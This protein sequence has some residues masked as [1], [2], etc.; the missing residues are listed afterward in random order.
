MR[1]NRKSARKLYNFERKE[2]N[3]DMIKE[4]LCI[5][6]EHYIMELRM[7]FDDAVKSYNED[8]R[9][10]AM[11]KTEFDDLYE[12]VTDLACY[13]DESA[14]ERICSECFSLQYML[15]ALAKSKTGK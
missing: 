3:A 2:I 12:V 10:F 6:V 4:H 13:L 8:A 1:S 15:N 14:C 9:L 7:A 11:T 5:K